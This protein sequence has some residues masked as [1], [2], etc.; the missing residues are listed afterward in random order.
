[1]AKLIMMKRLCGGSVAK[2]T[3][4]ERLSFSLQVWILDI[5]TYA[6]IHTH[7]HTQGLSM[8]WIKGPIAFMLSFSVFDYIKLHFALER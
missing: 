4:V 3:M 7:A 1:M 8:N 5:H 2:L 6:H